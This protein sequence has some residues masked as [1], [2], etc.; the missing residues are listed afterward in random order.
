MVILQL[1]KKLFGVALMSVGILF[2][3]YD[4]VIVPEIP[5]HKI[6]ALDLA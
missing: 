2:L 5:D 3:V 6:V 1:D 4:L